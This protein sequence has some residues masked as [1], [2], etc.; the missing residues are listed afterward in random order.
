MN[1]TTTLAAGTTVRVI[2]GFYRDSTGRV[3]FTNMHGEIVVDFPG[4]WRGVAFAPANLEIV[5][6]CDAEHNFC[7]C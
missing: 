2:A 6:V 4:Y 3:S 1:A 5:A 7:S